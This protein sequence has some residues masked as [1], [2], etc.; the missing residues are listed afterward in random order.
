MATPTLYDHPFYSNVVMYVFSYDENGVKAV[1]INKRMQCSMQELVNRLSLNDKLSVI[2][3]DPILNG[4]LSAIDR[5]LILHS[6]NQGDDFE[7]SFSKEMLVDIAKGH[8]PSFHQVFLG[9]SSWTHEDFAK[10]LK[11]GYWLMSRQDLRELFAARIA[12]R[13]QMVATHIGVGNPAYVS[14]EQAEA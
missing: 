13:Y 10:E 9:F 8:G 12:D 6:D 4:G 2:N 14:C 11:A 1:A 5:G 7:V 3:D